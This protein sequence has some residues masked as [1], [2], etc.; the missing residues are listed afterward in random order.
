MPDGR[1]EPAS[2]AKLTDKLTA[3]LTDKRC[4]SRVFFC[5]SV[6]LFFVTGGIKPARGRSA[7]RGGAF[8]V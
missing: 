2:V 4:G 6:L 7:Q 8:D 5:S 3:K 1:R